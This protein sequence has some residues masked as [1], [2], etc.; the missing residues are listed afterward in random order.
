MTGSRGVCF[1]PDQICG[2]QPGFDL[3]RPA[4]VAPVWAR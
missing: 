4:G 2:T 3:R 1:A